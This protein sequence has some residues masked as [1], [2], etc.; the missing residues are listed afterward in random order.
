MSTPTS[1]PGR[2][3]GGR[4]A[5]RST[6]GAGGMGTVWRAFDEVLRR[7]V[8]V[9]EVLLP[10]GVP[11]AERIMLCERTLREAR[12]AASLNV[13][14]VVTIYDV[15]EED[16]RPWI[17]M[18]LL[19][20]RSL[21]EIIRADGPLPPAVVAD[22]GLQVIVALDAAHRA[23]ILH[24]DVK[25]GNILVA[26]DGRATLTDFGVARTTGDS[27]LT[28]T[29]L[30]LGSPCYISPERAR[31][32]QPGPASDL[33]SLGATL[34]AAVEGRPPYD[35][36]DPLPTLT[37]IVTDP[38][39][40]CQLAGPLTEV[41]EGLLAKDPHQRW[42][43][44]QAS[45]ALRAAEATARSRD[46]L[47]HEAVHASATRVLDPLRAA[48]PPATPAVP[49]TYRQSAT[50]R[51]A[52][53]QAP[54]DAPSTDSRAMHAGLGDTRPTHLPLPVDPVL[55]AAARPHR[56]RVRVALL[57]IASVLL[58][59]AAAAGVYLYLPHLV[60]GTKAPN[61]PGNKAAAQVEF[62]VYNDPAGFSIK[63]PKGWRQLAR[64]GDSIDFLESRD[65][66]FLRLTVTQAGGHDIT[67]LLAGNDR[68]RETKTSDYQKVGIRTVQVAGR[69][70]GEWEFTYTFRG[71]DRHVVDRGLVVDRTWYSFYLSTREDQMAASRDIVAAIADSFTVVP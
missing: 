38:P 13:A 50:H 64:N 49:T 55:G 14:S 60:N 18:E 5:L 22:V 39:R 12:A 48:G 8:A 2:T 37:A 62:V 35:L 23:G 71:K 57:V 56:R 21:A 33:W 51:T 11:P 28:S 65:G 42:G 69:P 1:T 9:K 68:E 31:G 32:R 15:V 66:R 19:A 41:L 45:A 27:A 61:K 30:L 7:D 6:I 29:G 10:P 63:V 20:A 36:G 4:Y 52:V 67:E 53:Q 46:P 47:S 34:Y 59:A 58:M 54:A 16:D 43:V 24:R 17:V 26:A 44:D 70:G 25:P 40:P 3:I